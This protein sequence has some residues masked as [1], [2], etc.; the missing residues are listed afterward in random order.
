MGRLN[1]LEFA[2]LLVKDEVKSDNHLV[3]N[4]L[5]LI[6]EVA[7]VKLKKYEKIKTNKKLAKELKEAVETK[8]QFIDRY[9][10]L[11]EENKQLEAELQ[12]FKNYE[13]K[14]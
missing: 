4:S 2:I 3:Q 6:I 7:Q 5:E 13:L 14:E 11:L 10:K 8:K 12:K 9:F 1:N